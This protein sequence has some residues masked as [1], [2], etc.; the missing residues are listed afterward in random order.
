MNRSKFTVIAGVLILI[1]FSIVIV[2]SYRS[3]SKSNY[4]E[5][6]DMDTVTEDESGMDEVEVSE[7]E[8][9]AIDPND[10][11]VIASE[12]INDGMEF[13]QDEL[14]E[15]ALPVDY[16]TMPD[17][18]E[19]DINVYTLVA[20]GL[21]GYF[22]G[23]V[24]EVF[25]FDFQRDLGDQETNMVFNVSVHSDNYNL[26]MLLDMYGLKVVVTEK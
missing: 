8:I 18:Y 16:M 15:F 26:N 2:S 12:Q 5:Y 9:E 4:S 17:D 3:K 13:T 10:D 20:M 19:Y 11:N 24:P 14:D 22:G 25:D 7:I 23:N 1:T 6:K 21:N